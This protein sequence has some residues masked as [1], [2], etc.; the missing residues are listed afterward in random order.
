MDDARTIKHDCA[1]MRKL[2]LNVNRR[3]ERLAIQNAAGAHANG[4][5]IR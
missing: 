3:A 4:G 5:G 2:L 1:I